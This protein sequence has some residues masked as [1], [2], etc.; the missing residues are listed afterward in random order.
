MSRDFCLFLRIIKITA[1]RLFLI[2]RIRSIVMLAIVSA[3]LK[4]GAKTYQLLKVLGKEAVTYVNQLHEYHLSN[5]DNSTLDQQH[6][7]ND[8]ERPTEETDTFPSN[9]DPFLQEQLTQKET[10]AWDLVKQSILSPKELLVRLFFGYT[11]AIKAAGASVLFLDIFIFT[12]APSLL[13][14]YEW[15]RI[16]DV[17]VFGFIFLETIANVVAGLDISDILVEGLEK[18]LGLTLFSA[19]IITKML[20]MEHRNH[21]PFNRDNANIIF[22]VAAM[23]FVSVLDSMEF[24]IRK[25]DAS[26]FSLFSFVRVHMPAAFFKL[27]QPLLRKNWSAAKRILSMLLYLIVLPSRALHFFL[28]AITYMMSVQLLFS[29]ALP[30]N[31]II[32]RI[33]PYLSYA[34][35]LSTLFAQALALRLMR[36]KHMSQIKRHP[37]YYIFLIDKIIQSAVFSAY[38][39]NIC[40][41]EVLPALIAFIQNKDAFYTANHDESIYVEAVVLF[42]EILLAIVTAIRVAIIIVNLF[43]RRTDSLVLPYD[44]PEDNITT[45]TADEAFVESAN[46]PVPVASNLNNYWYSGLA[47]RVNDM[48]ANIEEHVN[49]SSRF[50]SFSSFSK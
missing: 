30:K 28:P 34:A 13:K 6:I 44:E 9:T 10:S 25:P 21:F 39:A 33:I 48:K 47:Q 27:S 18:T 49:V 19:T 20:A 8:E 29:R 24:L 42:H 45:K 40:M 15:T 1:N 43:N 26:L 22:L 16:L 23:M 46:M 12:Y 50:V 11:R 7:N 38:Q 4:T 32:D 5:S 14:A 31:E 2:E 17:A 3:A 35:A 36:Y 41:A 37:A